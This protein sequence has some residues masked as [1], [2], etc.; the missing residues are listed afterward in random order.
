MIPAFAVG[1][2][3]AM[4]LLIARLKAAGTIP[5]APVYLN[6]PMAIDATGIYRAHSDEHRISAEECEVMCR[7]ATY[8]HTAEESKA[9]NKRTGPMILIAGSGMMTG[10]RIL[11]HLV[12]FAPDPNNALLLV[13][14]QAA[15]TRGEAIDLGADEVKIHGD[16]VPV[17]CERLRIDGMSGHADYTEI[18][19]WLDAMS[20]R[21]AAVYVTHGDPPAAD[22]FRRYLG[23]RFG[24]KAVIPKHGDTVTLR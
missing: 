9:L 17:L 4:L 1:R 16:Y 2:S 6:S 24:W 20:V 3:Q 18:G 15:G 23:D 13:G 21:P 12:A 14:Y 7:A 10:G 22:A 8:V 5:D 19:D 11:H